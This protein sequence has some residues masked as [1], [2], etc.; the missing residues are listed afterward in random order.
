MRST[1]R[2]RP[3]RTFL[4]HSECIVY[5][6]FEFVLQL[7]YLISPR[8]Q[9]DFDALQAG[10]KSFAQSCIDLTSPP[11]IVAHVGT[12]DAVDDWESIR[13]ALGYDKVNLLGIS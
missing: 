4:F 10:V 11:G 5:C 9:E 7:L 2:R 13:L 6:I 1:A 3:S 12:Q 8:T